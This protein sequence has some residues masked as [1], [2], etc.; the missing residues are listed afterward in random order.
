M[1]PDLKKKKKIPAGDSSQ[2][3]AHVLGAT[4]QFPDINAILG[5]T[6]E[7]KRDDAHFIDGEAEV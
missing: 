7:G 5:T 3:P 4:K 6:P 1:F 2:E